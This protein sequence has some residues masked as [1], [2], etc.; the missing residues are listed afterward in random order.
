MA[1]PSVTLNIYFVRS[2]QIIKL[3]LSNSVSEKQYRNTSTPFNI[4]IAHFALRLLR[5][6]IS[7][8]SNRFQKDSSFQ[9]NDDNAFSLVESHNETEHRRTSATQDINQGRSMPSENFAWWKQLN[10][11]TLSDELCTNLR[12]CQI[13]IFHGMRDVSFRMIAI[14]SDFMMES[15]E[16]RLIT[17]PY[18]PRSWTDSHWGLIRCTWFFRLKKFIRL[19][20]EWKNRSKHAQTLTSHPLVRN[21]IPVWFDWWI[22]LAVAVAAD[23]Y[24]TEHRS[25]AGG[26]VLT[27]RCRC[28]TDTRMIGMRQVHSLNSFH[29]F[30]AKFT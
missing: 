8:E 11:V 26:I 2:T 5:Y 28:R 30:T 16:I 15:H 20:I 17:Q 23:E 25:T 9:S 1:R 12:L 21:F 3:D 27:H 22:F 10:P 18:S 7:E 19:P 24:Q 4:R 6:Y 14:K 13:I 29:M